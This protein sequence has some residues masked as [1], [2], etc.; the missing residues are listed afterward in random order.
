[1]SRPSNTT[2]PAVGT[3]DV[4]PGDAVEQGC[5]ARAVWTDQGKH[6]AFRHFEAHLVDSRQAAE[7]LDHPL[8]R[9]D[10]LRVAGHVVTTGSSCTPRL[11]SCVR[12][13]LGRRP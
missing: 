1:M 11:S 2:L 4:H 5:L 13:R 6:L 8:Q 9:E 7:A 10:C 3:W 12:R